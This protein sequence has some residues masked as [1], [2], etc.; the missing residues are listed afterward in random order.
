MFYSSLFSKKQ[1]SRSQA[2]P[3]PQPTIL[4]FYI[5]RHGETNENRA[6]II[7]GQLDTKL[8]DTGRRQAQLVAKACSHMSFVKA[9]TSDLERARK[10]SKSLIICFSSY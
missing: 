10:V 2:A 7:Q 6:G 9:L 1:G 8:N 3:K 4:R 5:I